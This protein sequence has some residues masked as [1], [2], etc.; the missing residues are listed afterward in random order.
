LGR[1]QSSKKKMTRSE[2]GL[3]SLWDVYKFSY[4][5]ALRSLRWRHTKQALRLLLEPCTY[6]RNVEVPAV[7][8][9]LHV[10]AGERILDIGS[11]KLPSLFL[12]S[13]MGAEVY[14]SDLLPYFVEEYSYLSGR[15]RRHN[16][17]ADYHIETQDARALIYP[18][19]Y[20]DKVYAISVLEHIEDE[21]D[22][23]AMREIARVLKVGGVC[24]LT[25]PFAGQ[26]REDSIKPK[27]YYEFYYKLRDQDP[28]AGQ[29]VFWQRRYDP[30][31]LR[32]RL[33]AP[34]GLSVST[35]EYYGERWFPFERFYESL[36]PAMRVLFSV[37][38]PAF[39][40]LFL[41]RLDRPTSSGLKAALL[42]L[43]KTQ[44]GSGIERKS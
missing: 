36:P 42:V 9:H 30:E 32:A 5:L 31:A 35:T 10:Q 15:L 33:I 12:W 40:K 44:S 6:W 16:S 13:R 17:G 38:G 41:Y 29:P 26:Y 28:A 18:A 43:R 11:P 24:C 4:L 19:N 14:A 3:I 39:S 27:L 23:Q 37:P 20:F 1:I 7:I 21:G 34:S 8:N 22:S 2:T 25:V